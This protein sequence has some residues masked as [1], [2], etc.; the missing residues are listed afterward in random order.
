MADNVFQYNEDISHRYVPDSHQ[1]AQANY[2]DAVDGAVRD[3]VRILNE[4]LGLKTFACCE[5]HN[6]K[7]TIYVDRDGFYHGAF[8]IF[9]MPDNW[10]GNDFVNYL[11]VENGYEW[12]GIQRFLGG[13]LKEGV[14]H[15]AD[16]DA[17]DFAKEFK[18]EYSD[19]CYRIVFRLDYLDDYEMGFLNRCTIMV[20]KDEV[21]TQKEW[22][23]IRDNGL[24]TAIEMLKR[25]VA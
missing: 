21:S 11:T 22:D 9:F 13:L 14:M 7:Q 18:D 3:P 10:I 16:I 24:I 19:I 1:C 2:L 5:G 23:I 6:D 12:K 15:R 8:I 17:C 25:Y 20:Q 4:E